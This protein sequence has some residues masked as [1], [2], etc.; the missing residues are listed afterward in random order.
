M[1]FALGER[2]IRYCATEFSPSPREITIGEISSSPLRA[3]E[4]SVVAVGSS[5]VPRSAVRFSNSA[6]SVVS[7]PENVSFSRE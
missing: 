6:L 4:T 2:S 5:V 7:E 1:V 3:T